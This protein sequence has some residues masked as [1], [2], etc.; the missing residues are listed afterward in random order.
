LTTLPGEPIATIGLTDRIDLSNALHPS[1]TSER[2]FFGQIYETLVHVD[3]M[4]RVRPGLAAS[5]R[6]DERSRRFW[7]VTLRENA[8]FSDG[9]PVTAADVRA[10]WTRDGLGNEFRTHVGRLVQGVDVLDDRTLVVLLSSRRY[11]VPAALAHPDLAVAKQVA[12]SS[13]PLGTRSSRLEPPSNATRGLDLSE[14]TVSRDH[15]PPLRFLVAPGD[16]RDLLDAGA[17][18]LV[19][20]HQATLDYAATLPHF[21]RLP[22][23]WQRTRI[24]LIPGRSPQAPPLSEDARQ[25]LADDAVRGEARGAHGPFWWEA[26]GCSIP[27]AESAPQPPAP[28]IVYDADDGAARDLAERFV[29]LARASSPAATA[30]L[31]AVLPD[32]PRRTFQRAS[33][34]TGKDLANARWL[35]A[36][37][38]YILSV[39]SRPLDPCH[40]LL[41]LMDT[42]P[43]L[44]PGT[45]IPLVDTRVQA[46]VRRGKS[47]GASEFDG[48]LVI[49]GPN[50]LG[51]R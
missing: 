45:I 44:T 19:T 48:A 41:A 14:L 23:P 40:E 46:V 47:G 50:D 9:T 3:C 15:L 34:L 13:L 1:N 27:R 17:D 36:D 5:W 51:S 4:G 29:G 37:A 43:W 35:G 10:G 21:Q 32:R 31:D 16:P 49:G 12:G 38:G 28:R 24:L 39:E 8:R 2:L 26:D 33:G 25:A 42:V 7:I 30:F 22:L 18:L 6:L 11:D 20:R